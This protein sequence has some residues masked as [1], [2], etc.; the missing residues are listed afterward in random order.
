MCNV[1]I[2]AYAPEYGSN[3]E[4]SLQHIP[5]GDALSNWAM[6]YINLTN[7]ARKQSE[8]LVKVRLSLPQ[9]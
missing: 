6:N 3:L 1:V 4:R 7:R 9:S 8:R 2:K 5:G